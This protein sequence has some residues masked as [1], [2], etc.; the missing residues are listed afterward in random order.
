MALVCRSGKEG[1]GEKSK[2]SLGE[3]GGGRDQTC[4]DDVILLN[5]GKRDA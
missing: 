1:C 4:S 3:K 5:G 2:G